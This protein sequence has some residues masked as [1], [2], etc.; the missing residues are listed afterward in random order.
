MRGTAASVALLPVLERAVEKF[1]V[2]HLVKEIV[3]TAESGSHFYN[4]FL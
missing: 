2:A 4:R 3:T 1:L